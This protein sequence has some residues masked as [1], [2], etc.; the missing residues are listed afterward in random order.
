N[1]EQIA[2]FDYKTHFGVAEGSG[3]FMDK[4]IKNP[5]RI[6]VPVGA[7]P[8]KATTIDGNPNN[9]K[10]TKSTFNPGGGICYFERNE[11]FMFPAKIKYVNYQV[12]NANSMLDVL[13][14][15]G[16]H[17][18]EPACREEN[19]KELDAR[20]SAGFTYKEV[21]TN[22]YGYVGINAG[23]I[24]DV[25][26]RRA[27]M[28]AMDTSMCTQYY[29]NHSNPIYR[30]M[31]MASWAYPEGCTSYYPYIGGQVPDDLSKV[32]PVYANYVTRL[33]KKAGETLTVQEQQNFLLNEL[34]SDYTVKGTGKNQVLANN[35]YELKYTFTIAGDSEDHPAFNMFN[36]A[37]DILNGINFKVTVEKDIRALSKL[38]NGELTVW[39]AAWGAAIDPDM[40]QVYHI[41]STAGSVKNWGYPEIKLGRK[42]AEFKD[43]YELIDLLSVDIENARKVTGQT[44][45][46]IRIKRAAIYSDALDKVMQLAVE[47]PSYQRNDLFAYNGNIID[48]TTLE[49]ELTAYNGPLAKLWEVSLKETVKDA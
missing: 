36:R 32:D 15:G 29:L 35:K 45:E 31:T 10:I 7:G 12:V 4:V 42:T 38:N 19:L 25:N 11:H 26:V 46:E 41:E 5:E 9:D 1:E 16:V 44:E 18:V 49:Q 34:L 40:Y 39:A 43:E 3:D 37:K 47:L 8:Y 27:I 2:L 30:P 13:F 33:G 17:F 22:G 14:S 28:Y 20:K 23:D 24:P 48:E 6:G 21:Q